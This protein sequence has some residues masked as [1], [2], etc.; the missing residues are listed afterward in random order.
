M[1]KTPDGIHY[2]MALPR[3]LAAKDGDSAPSSLVVKGRQFAILQL[4]REDRAQRET[5]QQHN[6]IRSFSSL[7]ST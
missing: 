3:N 4:D 5:R 1:P 7:T 6:S 2:H